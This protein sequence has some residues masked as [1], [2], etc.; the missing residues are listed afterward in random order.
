ME[1][2]DTQM[3]AH[4]ERNHTRPLPRATR[5][6]G[7]VDTPGS[8]LRPMLDR[9]PAVFYTVLPSDGPKLL[10]VSSQIERILGYQPEE[11]M[12]RPALWEQALYDDDRERV[13][14]AR[15]HALQTGEPLSLEYRIHARDG[16]T[17]WVR[18]EAVVLP[19]EVTGRS[20]LHGFLLDI[21]ERKQLETQLVHAQKLESIGELAAGI[22]HE[23]NTPTQFVGDNTRFLQDAFAAI[24]PVLEKCLAL[25]TQAAA[26]QATAAL[27]EDVAQALRA[28][29]LDYLKDEIPKAIQQSL[30]GVQRIA[31]IVRAMKDFS[32]PDADGFQVVDLNRAIDST[33]T[34]A[35]NEWKYVANVTTD[36]AADLPAVSCLP[37]EINQVLLNVIVNAAQA[38]RE[39]VGDAAA[40]K[41]EI[42]V[43][44]RR[45]GEWVE[46]RIAD[47]GP[48]IP[49][50]IRG[51][52]FDPFF[53]TK[54]VGK[55]TGQGL[56][57]AHN[58]V[59]K[60]HHGAI[61][62]DTAVGRGTT[63]IIRLP[64]D[65]VRPPEGVHGEETAHSAG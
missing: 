16:R 23:I 38:I 15:A 24:W 41:G 30:D 43:S 25:H 52:I 56:A 5:A 61:T 8:C 12:A 11:I 34:V 2:H 7:P 14:A 57:I 51:R 32:H 39:V 6:L 49:P 36:L 64:L 63:F 18:D 65:N 22:A 46:I 29:D 48:G 21:T 60:R 44:T 35:R 20:A 54:E 58:V 17:V 10:Y 3:L 13:L 53:T 40:G 55:G 42:R 50:A 9:L 27:C 37:G 45:D 62:F 26:G 47:S 59:V 28:A 1:P 31:T 4:P 33:L 19:D